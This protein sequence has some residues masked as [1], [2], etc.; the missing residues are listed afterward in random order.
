MVALGRVPANPSPPWIRIQPAIKGAFRWS[1]TTILIF[2]PDP[3]APLPHATNFIVTVSADATAVSGRRLGKP[4]EFSFTTPT[5]RLDV[6]RWMRRNGR[7]DQPVQLALTFNQRVRPEDVVAHLTV[8]YQPHKV[9]L[10]SFTPDERARL[11]ARD[12]NALQQFDAK[13]AAARAAAGRSDA[14]AIRPAA[15]WDRQRFPPSDRMVVVETTTVPP[16]GSWLQLTLQTS[17]P[18]PEGPARPPKPQVTTAELP[19]MFLVTHVYPC[20]AGCNPSGY[21]AVVFTEQV[22][23][24][25]FARTL[26]IADI[27]DPAREQAVQKKTA[28]VAAGRDTSTAHSVEDGGFDR[29]PPANTWALELDPSLRALDGQTLGY[30]WIGHRRE[31]AR[32]RVHELRRRPRRVGDGRRP[33]AAVLRA[34]LPERHAAGDAH[35]AQRSDGAHPGAA[36]IAIRADAAGRRHGPPAQRAARRDAVVRPRSEVDA[37]GAGHRPLLG[38]H[39]AGRSDRAIASRCRD[40]TTRRCPGHQPRYHREGQ[41]AVDARVRDAARQRRARRRRAAS[42]SSTPRARSSG[43]ARRTP[44]ASPSRRR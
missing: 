42:R 20:Q 23:A 44:T 21:N 24:A 6:A 2:T 22:D 27:T 10:P 1:G 16:P 39:R 25:E 34:Q 33:A 37:V 19:R 11:T 9:E 5:V 12:P 35:R 30:R 26:T 38:G 36:A 17:M 32:A 29:Q 40:D 31:L 18:S 28:V 3:A 8:R 7:F 41:P 43:A 15:D 13:L 14:L 4:F